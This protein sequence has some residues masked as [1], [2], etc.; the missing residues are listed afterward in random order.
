MVGLS[1]LL[2][3]KQL[4]AS[5]SALPAVQRIA[6]ERPTT[7]NEAGAIIQDE[8]GVAI[9]GELALLLIVELAALAASAVNTLASLSGHDVVAVCTALGCHRVV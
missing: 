6:L 4:I 5:R 7:I 2:D 1:D 3:L 8:V 9:D